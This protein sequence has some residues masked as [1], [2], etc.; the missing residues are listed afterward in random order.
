[1]IGL[2]PAIISD[3]WH[4]L[5]GTGG[6]VYETGSG[7]ARVDQNININARIGE[8]RIA[9]ELNGT[10][11]SQ[12]AGLV[13]HPIDESTGKAMGGIIIIAKIIEMQGASESPSASGGARTAPKPGAP[14]TRR[15]PRGGANP[16]APS[17]YATVI[18]DMHLLPR[19]FADKFERVGLDIKD[20]TIPM[21]RGAHR[22]KPDGLHTGSENWNKVWRDF[23]NEHKNPSKQEILD[24]LAKM[25]KDFGLE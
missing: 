13:P 21:E 12:G 18:E 11:P 23:F 20:Y 4:G 2:I 15:P 17:N 25:R 19:Q 8:G 10:R 7:A 16:A 3:M 9:G 1:M 14:S 5:T 24:H 22:L 6:M